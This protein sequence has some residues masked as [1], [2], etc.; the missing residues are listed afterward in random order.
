VNS[1]LGSGAVVVVAAVASV[2][3][4]GPSGAAPVVQAPARPVSYFYEVQPVLAKAGCNQGACHGNSEGRG[5]LKLSLR[6]EDP[7]GDLDVLTRHGG[8]RRVHLTEPGRSLLLLKATASIPHGGGQ[9]LAVGSA[10]YRL[11]AGW[12]AE[13]ARTDAAGAPRLDALEVTPRESLLTAPAW[14]QPLRVT[15]R[16][17]NGERRDLTRLSMYLPGDPRVAVSPEGAA[18]AETP[19]DS[20]V[21]VRFADRM[22]TARL[23]FLPKPGAATWRPVE[24]FNEIDALQFRRLRRLGLAPSALTTDSEFLRRA[25]LDILGLLP[26]PDET[27][28][29]LAECATE[30]AAPGPGDRGSKTARAARA[31]L[32]DR[33]L[34]RPEFADYWSLKWAD[35][36][37]VED[38]SLDPRGSQGYRDWIR[39][40]LANGKPMD[41]FARELLAA[42]GSTYANPPTNYYRRTRTA[43]EL[44]E[45]TAQLF[46]GTRM[47]CARCHNHPTERWK[48]DDYYALV[49]IFAR[50][51]RKLDSFARRDRFDKH[52]LN[53]EEEIS[54]ARSGEV[55][56]PR[57]GAAVPA[58]LPR[59]EHALDTAVADPRAEFARWL[60]APENP[61]FARTMVNRT[62]QSLF[63]KGLV[64]PVDDLR[65]SNPA[66]N[67]ELFDAL[68]REFVRS[69]YN[70]AGLVRRIMNSRTY[71]LSSEPN[72]ANRDDER[73]FSRALAR[74][75]PAE[76]L[77]DTL[78][79]VTGVGERFAGRPEG[80]RAVLL[81]AVKVKHPFLKLFGQPPRESVCDCERAEES[82]LGQSFALISGRIV[83]GKL[84]EPDNR[85]GTLLN[86]S[87]SD[88]EV[89]DELYLA[90]VAREP[91][92]AEREQARRYLEAKGPAAGARRG[93]W[94]DLL[95]ALLNSKEFLLRR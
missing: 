35:L 52:E 77:L 74:R 12:I 95:W 37:R 81:P 5:G 4:V 10:E 11:L 62:W 53:G 32:I 31:R 21:L 90:A 22:E 58:R 75:L 24:P 89:L 39:E 27:R 86:S 72:A 87:R 17:T 82:T 6:G 38:R 83:D 60:T 28:A 41:Q 18:S 65:D 44:G 50:V 46:M 19:V 9:R 94:E 45:S 51:E 30:R 61:F 92:S 47:L 64:D 26:T 33:L 36:L 3:A 85:L 23:T 67:P 34:E 20:A 2:L 73:F 13:G 43:V 78:G 25:Y 84:R 29:F 59:S 79:Q 54:V 71:Q 40:S 16:F 56:H 66:S 7:D 80:T 14:T 49:A 70:L 68:S 88:A 42:T 69:G 63:G 76:V 91:T 55:Q 93:A 1:P 8:G 48:Q 15:G 57:T